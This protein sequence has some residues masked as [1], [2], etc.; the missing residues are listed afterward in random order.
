[1]IYDL[2][3]TL[4]YVAIFALIGAIVI[5]NMAIKPIITKEDVTNLAR[6]GAVAG[7]S[8]VLTLA[9]GLVLWFGV[10]KPAAFYSSNPLFHGKLGLFALL[11]LFAAYPAIFFVA[12]RNVAS[13][14][15]EVPKLVRIFLKCELLIVFVIP[16]LAFLMARGIG[17]PS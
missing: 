2:V 5:E 7:L 16:F 15:I 4:H 9:L 13:E 12:Q 8:A 1:M 3:R 10:G 14:T 17:L 11:L 6:V